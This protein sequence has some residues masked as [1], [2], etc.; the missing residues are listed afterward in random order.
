MIDDPGGLK[1]SLMAHQKRALAWLMWRETRIPSG[2]ILGTNSWKPISVC[3]I[4]ELMSLHCACSRL[5]DGSC[6]QCTS[7]RHSSII[8]CLHTHVYLSKE[9][10]LLTSCALLVQQC[11]L[12]M[13]TTYLCRQARHSRCNMHTLGLHTVLTPKHVFSLV[14]C[15]HGLVGLAKYTAIGMMC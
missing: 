6:C 12:L 4:S 10:Q 13:V 2:G 11:T 7:L 5:C 9:K 3:F 8:L 15:S 1:V 14:F